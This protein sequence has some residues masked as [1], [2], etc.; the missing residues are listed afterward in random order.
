MEQTLHIH[1]LEGG[2]N[3]SYHKAVPPC[4]ARV[5]ARAGRDREGV[6]DENAGNSVRNTA[7]DATERPLLQA[8]A[9]LSL[10]MTFLFIDCT[11]YGMSSLLLAL[12][13]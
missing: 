12:V 3:A 13:T 5:S 2:E 9:F 7:E 4:E 10:N 8:F 1:I 11:L 6:M